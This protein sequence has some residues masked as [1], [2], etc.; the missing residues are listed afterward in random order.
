MQDNPF[1]NACTG[2]IA[3]GSLGVFRVAVGVKDVP[4]LADSPGPPDRRISDRGP[5]FENDVR[6]DH[7]RELLKNASHCRA[8]DRDVVLGCIFLHFKE[9]IAPRGQHGIEIIIYRSR[10]DEVVMAPARVRALLGCS[11]RLP[12]FVENCTRTAY[13]P[14]PCPGFISKTS[15]PGTSFCNSLGRP[16]RTGNVPKCI[17]MTALGFSK[18]HA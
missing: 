6:I 9:N 7:Q 13:P 8:D 18:L 11:H 15:M 17:G 5:Q 10:G 16:T 1:G 2:E 12:F 3:A 14:M 4:I